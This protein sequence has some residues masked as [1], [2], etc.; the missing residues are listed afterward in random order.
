MEAVTVSF[1]F[2]VAL[3]GVERAYS[4]M[5]RANA[6]PN[7]LEYARRYGVLIR[8]HYTDLAT[9]LKHE[10]ERQDALKKKHENAVKTLR[11]SLEPVVK[12]RMSKPC[13][14]SAPAG[15]HDASTQTKERP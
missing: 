7:P 5:V 8:N 6:S 4:F 9:H 10:I 2:I 12:A 14:V 11:E 13:F 15:D 3:L 1:R